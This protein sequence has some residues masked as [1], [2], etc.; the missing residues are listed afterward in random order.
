MIIVFLVKLDGNLFSIHNNYIKGF[1]NKIYRDKEMLFWRYDKN[2]Y[3]SSNTN[4]YLQISYLSNSLQDEEF[5]IKKGLELSLLL[6]RLFIL[7]KVPCFYCPDYF[8]S[9]KKCNYI[10][11]FNVRILNKYYGEMN[12]RENVY[13]L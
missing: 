1:D 5:Y 6:N 8:I 2:M 13:P 9:N 11:F 3:Y 4:K 10:Q 7:P 12:Y